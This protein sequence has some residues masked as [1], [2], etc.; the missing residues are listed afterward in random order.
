LELPELTGVSFL[1]TEISETLRQCQSVKTLAP[2]PARTTVRAP[3][4]GY[5]FQPIPFCHVPAS[6]FKRQQHHRRQR[7]VLKRFERVEVL[8]KRGLFKKGDSP[9]GLRKTKP[10][11]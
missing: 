10:D 6:Q 4:P 1:T 9:L 5:R 11:V 3:N 8:K 7:N 2:E